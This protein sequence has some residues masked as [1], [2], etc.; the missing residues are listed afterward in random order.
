MLDWVESDS[1]GLVQVLEMKPLFNSLSDVTKSI[2]H[3]FFAHDDKDI[4]MDSLKIFQ[5][6]GATVDDPLYG[7]Y[8][9]YPEGLFIAKGK[10]PN[11]KDWK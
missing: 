9:A 3:R 4:S 10:F 8:H 6:Q 1:P 5:K 11:L 7:I 2:A